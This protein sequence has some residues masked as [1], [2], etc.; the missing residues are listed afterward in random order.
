MVSFHQI[1]ALQPLK[2]NPLAVNRL[3][4]LMDFY[5]SL[6][7]SALFTECLELAEST[8]LLYTAKSSN[9]LLVFNPSEWQETATR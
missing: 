6:V 4:P 3:T 5:L 9:S 2:M 8:K 1:S 7:N